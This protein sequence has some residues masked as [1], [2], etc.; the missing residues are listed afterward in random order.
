LGELGRW[1]G[2]NEVRG[3]ITLVVAGAAPAAAAPP[4]PTRLAAAVRAAE[5]DGAS[6]KEAIAAVA[7][8]HGLP[9]RAVYDAVL[10]HR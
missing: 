1:A 7:K 8:R 4:D 3:E 9:K 6:R 10:H 2:E 5:A